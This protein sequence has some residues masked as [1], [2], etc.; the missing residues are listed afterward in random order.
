MIFKK[1]SL[2]FLLHELWNN[3][4]PKRKFQLLFLLLLMFL[5]SLSEIFSI[6]AVLPFLS[7]LTNPE[8]IYN[9]QFSKL[10]IFKLGI[11]SPRDLLYPITFLFALLVFL[12]GCLR[13]ILI[14]FQTR[15]SFSIG[16]DLS[17]SIYRKTL[18]QPYSVHISRN[19]SEIISVISNKVNGV[20]INIL[21]PVLTITS[22]C[23]MILMII[24]ALF[25]INPEVAF[26]S[27][28]S[29]G[30]I[31]GLIIL[32]T[33]KK[34]KEDGN[35]M[36]SESTKV[37]QILQEGLGG[38]RDVLIEGTQNL[39]CDIFKNA[40]ISSRRAQ[41]NITIIS[42]SPRYGIESFGMIL[43]AILAY[44]MSIREQGFYSAIP[45]LGALALGAQKLLPLL[46]QVYGGWS[47]IKG[48]QAALIETLK[49]LYQ[50]L[51]ESINESNIVPIKFDE[52]IEFKNLTFKY[53]SSQIVINDISLIINKG[54][55][56]GII[57]QTGG[58]K[59][60]FLDILMGLLE[61]TSGSLII[62]DE[63]LD[64][65]NTRNWQKH[66]SHVPQ[67][68]YLTDATIAENIAFGV[69]KN[70]INYEIIKKASN[71]AQISQTIDLMPDQYRSKV[72]ERGSKL[73]GGQ[74]QRIGIARAFYKQ[75][76]VIIFDEATSALDNKTE[77]NIIEEIA[78]LDSNMTIFI[79]AHRLSTLKYC[80][81]VIEFESGKIKSIKNYS[82][83]F[84]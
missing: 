40:E 30:S 13:I 25:F 63:K 80:D 20:I 31:Y 17:T 38:I 65:Y 51:P 35:K 34:I 4:N 27:L 29:F 48:S 73:S 69:P 7:V 6:G 77:A 1:K 58:G 70:L 10:F 72:G 28:I 12:S 84:L 42:N 32:L 62:D 21:I 60:T 81:R 11:K 61:P 55:K 83:L 52:K 3:L 67:S 64:K 45:I 26:F 79:V 57:G 2:A 56:I 50:P 71:M 36:N 22:S 66:I 5:A 41:S 75:S 49:L 23:L 78:K 54:E 8:K 68:I 82:D 59:S 43:I 16:A 46:Q 37:I 74:K 53:D 19:T 15:L 24:S 9:H 44:Y 33:K 76:D 18:Y 39:Y 47:T 14:W